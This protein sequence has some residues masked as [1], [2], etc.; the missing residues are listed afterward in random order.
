MYARFDWGWKRA[1]ELHDVTYAPT[2]A[3]GDTLRIG[4]TWHLAEQ[5]DRSWFVFIHIVDAEENIVV[6]RDAEPLDETHP[7]NRWV[8]GD[9]YRD[10]HL[11]ALRDVPPGTYRV[12]IGMWNPQD[13]ERLGVYDERG[14]LQGDL[15][16]AGEVVITAAQPATP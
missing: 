2:A 12:R 7:T 14:K 5:V 10:T 6:K 4:L 9:W 1:F 11:V 3:S 16:E 8:V 15:I 13:G